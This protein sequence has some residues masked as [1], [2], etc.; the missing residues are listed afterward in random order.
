M[1]LSNRL[2]GLFAPAP[3]PERVAFLKGQPY[4]HRGLHGN[5]ILENS[6]A[7]F[8][9]AIRQGH[10]IECDV[11]AAEDGRA[12]VFHD[13]ELG[14]L[15]GQSGLLAHMRAE[16][17]DRVQLKDGHG[18]IPRLRE[19]LDQVGG[20]VPILIEL[21]SRNRRV[22]PLCLSVRRALE[23]Y[24]GKAAIMS[25]NPLVSAWFR[26]NAAHIVRGLVITEEGRKNLKGRIVRHQAL[27]TAKP[28]FL[29]YDIRDLP[30]G[31]AASCRARGMPVL[32]W[33]VR[34]AEQEKIAALHADE[35]VYEM[36]QT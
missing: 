36:P 8:D 23:G 10:G 24:G 18:K 1:S 28:D 14:R 17:I 30:S 7:A 26:K 15:T 25:F 35:P 2:D 34:S 5:G 13:F 22:G 4:A 3:Q 27:W 21:K 9:A 33:T 11:Q 20:R 32:T 12:F 19:M 29:A 31:F 6:P 16:E